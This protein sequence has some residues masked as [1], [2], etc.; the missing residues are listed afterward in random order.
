MRG[1]IRRKERKITHQEALEIIRAAEHGVLATVNAK[2]QPCTVCLNHLLADN[3]TLYFHSG[4]AGEKL[5]NIRNNPEVSY[6]V[7]GVSDVIYDQ[8]T[9]AYSSAVVNGMASIVEDPDEKLEA[10]TALVRR[11]SSD[12]IPADVVTKFINDGVGYVT[13]FKLE[14]AQITGKAR[15][16]RKRPCLA[17]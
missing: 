8:F 9:T 14:P 13:I 4:P 17:Y 16:S 11:Y 5:D 1:E 2:N 10:L 6:F 3:G 15:L 7:T 12:A